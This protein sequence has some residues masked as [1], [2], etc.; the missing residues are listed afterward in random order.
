MIIKTLNASC[1][2]ILTY[3]VVSQSLFLK[4]KQVE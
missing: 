4:A 2:K 3:K 1:S